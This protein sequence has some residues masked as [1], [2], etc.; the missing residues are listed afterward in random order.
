MMFCVNPV[1]CLPEVT[2]LGHQHAVTGREC[3]SP[4]ILL[5]AG[6]QVS[7]ARR[8]HQK[9]VISLHPSQSR[10]DIWEICCAPEPIDL[11]LKRV[12]LKP[13]IS[14][15]EW[16][17]FCAKTFGVCCSCCSSP[18]FPK[19]HEISSR[20]SLLPPGSRLVPGGRRDVVLLGRPIFVCLVQV[21]FFVPIGEGHQDRLEMCFLPFFVHRP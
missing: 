9:E 21:I 14:L 5:T 13:V 3:R 10:S 12:V 1:C 16:C 20:R 7:T 17:I 4:Y 2:Q 8:L 15:S 19:L 6:S 18:P 11:I